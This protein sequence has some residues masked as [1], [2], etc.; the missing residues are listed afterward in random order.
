MNFIVVVFD[1]IISSYRRLSRLDFG[2]MDRVRDEVWRCVEVDE[3]ENFKERCIRPFIPDEG[4][5]E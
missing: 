5:V 3:Q 2:T 4:Q 1:G